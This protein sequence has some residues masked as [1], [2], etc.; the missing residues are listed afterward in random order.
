MSEEERQA[1]K[2]ELDKAFLQCIDDAKA[3]IHKA[4]TE[5]HTPVVSPTAMVIM[6]K[7]PNLPPN[8]PIQLS[9]PASTACTRQ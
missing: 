9:G 5:G 7:T 2:E 8:A 4:M 6:R 3:L 1:T